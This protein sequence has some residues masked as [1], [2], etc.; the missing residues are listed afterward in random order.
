[1]SLRSRRNGGSI[2][3]RIDL[4]EGAP[5]TKDIRPPSWTQLVNSMR[6]HG[7]SFHQSKTDSERLVIL[8]SMLQSFIDFFKPLRIHRGLI[9]LIFLREAMREVS[10]GHGH[11]LFRPRRTSRPK[12][13]S[14]SRSVK[15]YS[16]AFMDFLMK[17]GKRKYE[18]AREV[19]AALARNNVRLTHGGKKASAKTVA[20]W[21]D[22]CVGH[23]TDPVR[24]A[25]DWM[26]QR[27]MPSGQRP[28]AQQVRAS[29][30]LFESLIRASQYLT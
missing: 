20:A 26:L 17:S 30:R 19:A 22:R 15:G 24:E 29:R 9:P 5:T 14:R 12:E 27:L 2:D 13:S 11:S 1:M 6:D 28:D 25:F 16:A 18:A 10:E 8:G 3:R 21:R 4:P 7:A 23:S